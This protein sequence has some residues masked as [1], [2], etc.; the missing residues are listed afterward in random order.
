M[1]SFGKNFRVEL[2]GESHGPGVGVI[3]DGC[4]PGLALAPGDF[5]QDLKRRKSGAL[6]TT[7]RKETDKPEFLSG[8]YEGKS[9]GSPICAFFR[10]GD[11]K[12]KDYAQFYN[13]PRPG[14]ADFT[15]RIKYGGYSDPRGSGHF[16][17][18]VT[19][20]LVVAGTI[21]KKILIPA[22]FSTYISI[23]G[24]RKD[25]EAVIEEALES[26]DSLG[27][28]VE[29]RI[30]GLPAGL[31]EPFFD[32]CE[33][34][35][36]H[37]I[38]AVPAVRGLEFGDGFRATEKRGSEHNDPFVDQSGKTSRNGSGGI[39]GGIANGNEMVFRV[40]VKPASSISRPQE[41]FDFSTGAMTTLEIEGRHDTC[42]AL[43]SAVVLESAAAI[44][45]A[46]LYLTA[47]SGVPATRSEL[48][49][50]P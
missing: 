11:T 4:P 27:A 19:A 12:S 8:I 36:A 23:V 16:S 9:T 44:A 48:W 34:M 3:I 28:I 41:T 15:S 42:I 17:G 32:A 1:N 26:G 20:G 24:G 5:D 29:I 21:A 40:A 43:R 30:C 38:F 10:N 35:I 50:K 22:G 39:N 14:H 37:A 2:F 25:I 45:L 18:R 33:S 46:D 13:V 31:G 47:K 49:R 6:G 7:P